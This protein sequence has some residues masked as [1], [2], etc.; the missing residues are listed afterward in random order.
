MSVNHA[1]DASKIVTAAAEAM[2]DAI[3]IATR[4]DNLIDAI[5]LRNRYEAV[6]ALAA[7]ALADLAPILETL[8][9]E[10]DAKKESTKTK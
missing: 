9:A 1:K 2:R 6:A 10:R 5:A 4:G 8:R 7:D 3:E